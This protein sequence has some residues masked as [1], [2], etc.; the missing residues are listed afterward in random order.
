[1]DLLVADLTGQE[2]SL[3]DWLREFASL[4]ERPSAIVLCSE[5]WSEAEWALRDAG[6]RDVLIG[7]ISGELLAHCCRRMWSQS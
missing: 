6:I 2:S 1:M 4:L 5:Q 3:W 7:D